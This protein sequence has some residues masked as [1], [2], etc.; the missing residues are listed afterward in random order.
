LI[1]IGL[2]S[3]D[4]ALQPLLASALG[5]EFQVLVKSNEYEINQMLDVGGFDVVILDLDSGRESLKERVAGS[6][7]IIVSQIPSVVMADDGL[8][9][10]AV[11]LI[12]L[13]AYGSCRRPPSMRDLKTMLHRAHGSARKAPRPR[14][15]QRV[16]PHWGVSSGSKHPGLLLVREVSCLF[17]RPAR[18]LERSH[19]TRLCAGGVTA[20]GTLHA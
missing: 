2:Y 12:R 3:E 16:E 7:R 13:G 11:E 4:R 8:R 6:R 5:K 15:R 18:S 19:F 20:S 1:R 14:R 9:T 10:A 17:L